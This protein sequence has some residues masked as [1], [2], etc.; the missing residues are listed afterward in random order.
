MIKTGNL[1]RKGPQKERKIT[2]KTKKMHYLKLL[3]ITNGLNSRIE[4]RKRIYEC[5][6]DPRNY[7]NL[8]TGKTKSK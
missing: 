5:E 3:K 8:K 2:P 4:K 7:S 6:A 1:S